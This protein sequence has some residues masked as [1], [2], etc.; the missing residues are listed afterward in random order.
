MT[1]AIYPRRAHAVAPRSG[2][3]GISVATTA[4]QPG[5]RPCY[6]PRR[7]KLGKR[8]L[9]GVRCGDDVLELDQAF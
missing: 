4:V 5:H 6:L 3:N 7:T 8:S 2:V 9:S 1:A